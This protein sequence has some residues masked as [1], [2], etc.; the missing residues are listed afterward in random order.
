MPLLRNATTGTIVATRIDPLST[1]F[2]RAV[3]LLARTAMRPDEGVWIRRCGAIHTIGMRVPIDVIF[4]D[5]D[6]RVMRTVADVPPNR[7]ALSCRGAEAVVELGSGAL[8]ECDVLPGDTL[9]LVPG[10]FG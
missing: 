9:E 7:L 1:F 8:R 6:S 4:V 10:K 3:G 2:Q 5:G